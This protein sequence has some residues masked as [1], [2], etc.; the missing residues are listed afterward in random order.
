MLYLNQVFVHRKRLRNLIFIS[1]SQNIRNGIQFR[2]AILQ[3]VQINRTLRRRWFVLLS[4]SLGEIWW[5]YTAIEVYRNCRISLTV[6]TK[7]LP[8]CLFLPHLGQNLPQKPEN[9]PH[10]RTFFKIMENSQY[11]L[12]QFTA[13]SSNIKTLLYNRPIRF[14]P[15]P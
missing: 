3:N 12:P 4:R 13:F 9:L 6:K 5:A 8:H 14:L 7:Y 1:V 10:I 2:R 15:V 11:F